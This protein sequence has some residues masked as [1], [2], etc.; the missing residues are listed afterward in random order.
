MNKEEILQILNNQNSLDLNTTFKIFSFIANLINL[1]Q[2]EDAQELVIYT[3]ENYKKLNTSCA[4]IFSDIVESIGFYPYLEKYKLN[5]NS[6]QT[7][8]RKEF[9]YSE[10]LSNGI[11]H[12]REQRELLNKIY[13][14]NMIVSAPTSFG[15]SLLIQEIVATKK[16]NNIVILQPTLALLDETRKK[17]KTLFK[18]I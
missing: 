15:K 16:Y 3:L 2:I 8:I 9:F 18:Y 6:T 7:K 13:H 4:E 12:H 11:Y 14:K 1:N 5:L 17:I 10:N